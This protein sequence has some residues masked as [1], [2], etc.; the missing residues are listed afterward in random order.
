MNKKVLVGRSTLFLMTTLTGCSQVHFGKDAVT[1]GSEKK[2]SFQTK[3]KKAQSS[4]KK[5]VPKKKKVVKKKN[6]KKVTKKKTK[7]P[8]KKMVQYKFLCK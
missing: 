6:T 5:T 1:I 7:A 8:K 3:V 4:S 2:E